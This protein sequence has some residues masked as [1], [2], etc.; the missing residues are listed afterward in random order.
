[1]PLA[2]R[3][4]HDV[5]ALREPL[6]RLVVE[7][8]ED[9]ALMAAIQGTNEEA[10]ERRFNA[11]HRAYLAWWDG[12]PAAWGWV[13]TRTAEIGELGSTF[14]I[15]EGERYLWNF[16]TLPA[17]RGKGIYPR[18]L[19]AIVQAEADEADC[20]WIVFA[21]EN[22]ASGAGIRKAGFTTVAELSY[23]SAGRPAVRSLAAGG[24]AAALLLGLP[25]VTE[26]LAPC[27]HCV[28][29]ARHPGTPCR[30]G[31]CRCDY[32]KLRAERAA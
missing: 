22:H 23:D 19:D 13:A 16:V 20:F 3:Y 14:T 4:R 17:H 6:A 32:Q 28:R 1:M 26:E 30:S 29:A 21:P 15:P 7:R 12:W 2:L 25:L 31:Q 11:G 27:W 18:L 10:I 8:E 24:E 5:P 9:V